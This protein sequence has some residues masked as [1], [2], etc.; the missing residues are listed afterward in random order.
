MSNTPTLQADPP[1]PPTDK[2]AEDDAEETTEGSGTTWSS[3]ASG[4]RQGH[5]QDVSGGRTVDES[6]PEDSDVIMREEQGVDEINEID[7]SQA[8]DNANNPDDSETDADSDSDDYDYEGDDDNY[9][10]E[11]DSDDYDYDCEDNDD[12]SDGADDDS[13]DSDSDGN[14]SDD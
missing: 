7:R 10:Y 5:V 2:M 1:E 9:N 8:G 12:D 4:A 14:E 3:D 13:D 11:D 6:Q